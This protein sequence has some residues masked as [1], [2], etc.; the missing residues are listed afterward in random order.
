MKQEK[1]YYI[2]KCGEEITMKK[3]YQ[4]PVVEEIELAEETMSSPLV[5]GADGKVFEDLFDFEGLAD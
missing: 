1:I 4:K 2:I 3:N 5:S